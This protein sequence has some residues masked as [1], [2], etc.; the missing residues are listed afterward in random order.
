MRVLVLA[1]MLA[2]CSAAGAPVA[3]RCATVREDD[4][5]WIPP[6]DTMLG[7]DARYPEEG[8]PR[9]VSVAGFWLSTHEV[10]TAEFARFVGATGHRTIA[11]RAPPVTPQTPPEMRLPGGAVFA[12]PDDRDPR[13][14]RWQPGAQWR[15]PEASATA[16]AAEPVVQIAYQDALAYARWRGVALP[17]EAQWERAARL[18][19]SDPEHAPADKP[20]TA[21]IWQGPFP[22]RDLGGDGFAVR[23]PVGC[24]PRD[25]AG[26]FDMIGNVW[27]WTSDTPDTTG[28]RGIIK[29]G[30]YLCAANYCARY[31]PAARQF[32][33]RALGTDHIGF[34]VIDPHRPPPAQG[35]A[36]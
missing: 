25:A 1:L 32:Q 10:T 12:T 2:G 14:W 16:S 8:P 23:A 30:S 26:L 20:A 5:V 35:P 18:G 27:E 33:E 3:P 34:R 13:W 28:A 29:G 9:R 11:E 17:S 19:G 24:F 21:N 4:M 7:Q 6:G 36:T 31:Q 15:R 22:A